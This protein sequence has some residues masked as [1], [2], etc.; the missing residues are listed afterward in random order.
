M[1]RMAIKLFPMTEGEAKKLASDE[2]LT[3]VVHCKP[4]GAHDCSTDG[5]KDYTQLYTATGLLIRGKRLR[6]KT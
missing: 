2:G 4:S 3:L 5:S 1:R 6:R